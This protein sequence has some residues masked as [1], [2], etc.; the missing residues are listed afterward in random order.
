MIF[1]LVPKLL[2]HVL[3]YVFA[4]RSNLYVLK[5][6]FQ[7]NSVKE[8]LLQYMGHQCWN[9]ISCILLYNKHLPK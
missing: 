7:R 9:Q 4:Y 2:I 6:H 3:I 5:F 8:P 1:L